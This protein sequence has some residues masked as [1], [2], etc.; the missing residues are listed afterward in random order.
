MLSNEVE[1]KQDSLHRRRVGLRA[2]LSS[3]R[4]QG[5]RTVEHKLL[6][7]WSGQLVA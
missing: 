7:A 6:V 5:R 2:S 1:S 3:R 4:K